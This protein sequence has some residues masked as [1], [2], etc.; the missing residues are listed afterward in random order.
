MTAEPKMRTDD[1][2]DSLNN[3]NKYFSPMRGRNI[4]L[5]LFTGASCF[6]GFKWDIQN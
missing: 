3:I 4:I 2:D 1:D 6:E 5:K